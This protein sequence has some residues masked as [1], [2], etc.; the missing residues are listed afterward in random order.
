M[1]LEPKLEFF[2]FGD[3]VLP[4]ITAVRS[5]PW[6]TPGSTIFRIPGGASGP[7]VFFL[8]DAVIDEIF[9]FGH[10]YLSVAFDTNRTAAAAGKV[11]LLDVIVA[12][13]G[14]A[15]PSHV[16]FPA[17]GRVLQAGVYFEFVREP[18]ATAPGVATVCP[19]GAAAAE[20]PAPEM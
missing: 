14:A 20:G 17:L 11:H 6:H 1:Q 7:A 9:G 16:P 5:A 8:G 19:A 12:N 13:G 18:I 3:E 10:P 4:N 2:E 15:V